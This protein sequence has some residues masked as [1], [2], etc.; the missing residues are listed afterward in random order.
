MKSDH[1][2]CIALAG[3]FQAANLV[4]DIAYNGRCDEEAAK[5]CIYSLFQVDA[6]SVPDVYGGLMGISSGLSQLIGQLSGKEKRNTEIT[7]YVIAL[8]H[9]ER[10]LSKQGEM[11]NTISE[12]IRLATSRLEHYPMLHQNI[13]GQLADIYS[14]T[15]STLQPRIMVNGEPLHLQNSDNTNYIR[16]LL[17][18]GIRS[19]M[20]WQQCGG[21]RIQLIMQRKKIIDTAINVNNNIQRSMH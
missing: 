15:L 20:L 7:G 12:G 10:K 16:S 1:D 11:L 19:A 3:M 9:L 21:K 2:R 13:L 4:S 6:D 14:Q 5:A 18:A 8:M 17:L